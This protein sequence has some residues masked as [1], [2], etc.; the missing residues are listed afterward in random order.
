MVCLHGQSTFGFRRGSLQALAI[1]A[2]SVYQMIKRTLTTLG[3]LD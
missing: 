2:P 3:T 1:P